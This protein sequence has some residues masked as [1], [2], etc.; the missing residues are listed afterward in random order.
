MVQKISTNWIYAPKIRLRGPKNRKKLEGWYNQHSIYKPDTF[1]RNSSPKF[2][3]C[4]ALKPNGRTSSNDPWGCRWLTVSWLRAWKWSSYTTD[5]TGWWWS[6]KRSWYWGPHITKNR[7]HSL[8][9]RRS[10]WIIGRKNELNAGFSRGKLTQQVL[11]RW[12]PRGIR[13][14]LKRRRRRW[15]NELRYS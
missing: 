7:E 8:W 13:I 4:L 15:S 5:F 9:G 14:D 3:W 11:I 1:D 2:F 12:R 6:E 10:R